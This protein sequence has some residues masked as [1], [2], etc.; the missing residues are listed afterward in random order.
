MMKVLPMNIRRM[1][2]EI[3]RLGFVGDFF[4]PIPV[5]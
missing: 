4:E 2:G 5:D 3:D 1:G